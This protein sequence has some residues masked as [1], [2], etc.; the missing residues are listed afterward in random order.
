MVRQRR[1]AAFGSSSKSASSR[2]FKSELPFSPTPCTERLRHRGRASR[3][4][5]AVGDFDDAGAGGDPLAQRS[6]KPYEKHLGLLDAAEL[7]PGGVGLRRQAPGNESDHGLARSQ[8]EE[9]TWDDPRHVV[10]CICSRLRP[11]S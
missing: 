6:S 7:T 3:R 5:I 4:A 2:A 1:P 9:I 8:S 11:T 10:D